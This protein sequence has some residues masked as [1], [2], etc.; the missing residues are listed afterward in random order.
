MSGVKI[1]SLLQKLF[2]LQNEKIC[3][4]GIYWKT[5]LGQGKQQKLINESFRVQFLALKIKIFEFIFSPE[6]RRILLKELIYLQRIVSLVLCCLC[7]Y[8]KLNQITLEKKG[9]QLSSS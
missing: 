5:I 7:R 9:D 6:E 2:M 4:V 3:A 1:Q 8:M